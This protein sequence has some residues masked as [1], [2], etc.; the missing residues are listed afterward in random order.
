MIQ[1]EFCCCYISESDRNG[2]GNWNLIR[3]YDELLRTAYLTINLQVVYSVV[4]CWIVEGDSVC[5][6]FVQST[7]CGSVHTIKLKG[8]ILQILQYLSI[9]IHYCHLEVG[10]NLT[11]R[12]SSIFAGVL[13]LRSVIDLQ[14]VAQ[15]VS[16]FFFVCVCMRWEIK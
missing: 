4:P 12:L 10:Y 16:T 11:A 5:W 8:H 7:V 14:R 6:C 2:I 1:K 3:A 15:L 9:L 13:S